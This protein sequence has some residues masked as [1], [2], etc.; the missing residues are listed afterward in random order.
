MAYRNDISAP[1]S[2]RDN[3]PQF[4]IKKIANP[5]RQQEG[6]VN[7]GLKEN[8]TQSI[9]EIAETQQVWDVEKN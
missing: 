6:F 3:S 8:P 5:L 9:R 1:E 4:K 7:F 2:L